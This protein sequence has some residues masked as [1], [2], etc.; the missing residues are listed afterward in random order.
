MSAFLNSRPSTVTMAVIAI[1]VSTALSIILNFID[2][3]NG[4]IDKGTFGFMIVISAIALIFPYKIWNGSKG[5]MYAY[6]IS[7]IVIIALTFLA[8]S[9]VN[10]FEDG[11]LSRWDFRQSI[12][13]GVFAIVQLLS[14]SSRNWLR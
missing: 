3:N 1:L 7:F 6:I 12:L 8:A 10:L 11:G 13:A 14:S 4:L 5:W 2:L 9:E